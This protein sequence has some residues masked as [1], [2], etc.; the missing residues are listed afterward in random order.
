MQDYVL[1]SPV[2]I[3]S[4]LLFELYTCEHIRLKLALLMYKAW[5]VNSMV[6]DHDGR[7][8]KPRPKIVIDWS[9]W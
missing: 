6:V 9:V 3:M 4:L 7:P 5:T 1:D 2:V 8:A